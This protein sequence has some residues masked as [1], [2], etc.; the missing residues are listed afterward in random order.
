MTQPWF[1]RQLLPPRHGLSI[2]DVVTKAG[3]IPSAGGTGPYLSFR[4][5]IPNATRQDV[6]DTVVDRMELL[7]L[8]SVRDTASLVPRAAVV[9]TSQARSRRRAVSQAVR[10]GSLSSPVNENHDCSA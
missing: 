4:S 1:E 9:R 10:S 3:W 2:A 7:E 8:P 6:D 5:R